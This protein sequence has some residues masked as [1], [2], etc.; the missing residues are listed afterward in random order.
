MYT[1]S[2]CAVLCLGW[3]CLSLSHCQLALFSELGSVLP[4]LAVSI[5][6]ALPTR[7]ILGARLCPTS[8]TLS[9]SRGLAAR[10]V[11]GAY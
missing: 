5:S 10:N 6:L 4:Q 1:D 11:L 8:H 9:L 2:A 7:A 3:L